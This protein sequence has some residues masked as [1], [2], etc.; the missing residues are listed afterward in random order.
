MKCHSS[1][2]N[3]VIKQFLNKSVLSID[4]LCFDF[5]KASECLYLV[6]ICVHLFLL[7][8]HEHARVCITIYWSIFLCW[9]R[10]CWMHNWCHRMNKR[11]IYLN[12]QTYSLYISFQLNV[13]KTADA[14]IV[15]WLNL[16]CFEKCITFACSKSVCKALYVV[17]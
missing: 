17:Q 3:K 1:K 9:P 5:R 7:R 11:T 13:N 14:L 8:L 15:Y 16:Q 4:M 12:A 2:D 6:I 10:S